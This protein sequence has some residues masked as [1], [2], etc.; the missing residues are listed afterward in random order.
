MVNP[1]WLRAFLLVWLIAWGAWSLLWVAP[2]W[3]QSEVIPCA[4]PD[5]RVAVISPAPDYV[6]ERMAAGM[7]LAH[8]LAAIAAKDAPTGAVCGPPVDRATLP[9]RRFRDSWRKAGDAVVVDLPLA[10]QQRASELKLEL[11][12][13]IRE[14]AARELAAAD[15]DDLAR[16]AAHKAHRNHLRALQAAV[17][18]HLGAVMTPEAL[19]AWTPAYPAPPS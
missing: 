12:G 1:K 5:G 10:R 16:R 18:A 17:A 15:S 11:D 9:G 7:S 2:G 3:T 4:L 19:H 6:N 8:V 13:K 14:S